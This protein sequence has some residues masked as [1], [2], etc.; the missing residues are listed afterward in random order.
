MITTAVIKKLLALT[1]FITHHIGSI[2][3]HIMTLVIIAL[4]V[5]T[6]VYTH[7]HVHTE[8]TRCAH[9]AGLKHYTVLQTHLVE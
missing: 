9:A 3:C 6:H 1:M 7:T 4:G 5:D 8:E 2:S